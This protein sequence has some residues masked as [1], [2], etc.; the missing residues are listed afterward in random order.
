[1]LA[2]RA[3]AGVPDRE[4]RE[5]LLPSFTFAACAAAVR[6]CGFDCVFVDVDPAGWHLDPEKT[7]RALLARG[8]KVAAVLGASTFGTAPPRSQTDA[9]QRAADEAGVGLVVD[10]AAG[11]GSERPDGTPLAGQ[12]DAEVFSFHATKAFAIGEGGVVVSSRPEVADA[13]A[14]LANF[15]FDEHGAV[16]GP[17]GLNAKMAELPAAVGLAALDRFD[18]VLAAR[19]DRAAALNAGLVSAGV[20]AQVGASRSAWQFLPLLAPTAAARDRILE[21]GQRAGIELRAYFAM[22]LHTMP[23]LSR[24]ICADSLSITTDLAS[25]CLSLPMADDLTPE[26]IERIINVTG[27]A[28]AAC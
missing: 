22:P 23:D 17:L 14:R 26:E 8:S 2:L 6:W 28:L 16:S 13:V 9:W 4:R 1:M 11:F 19:R 10:S 15:G 21:A 27:D 25:R 20:T 24:E 7:Q 5:V 3:V 18:A 12:G